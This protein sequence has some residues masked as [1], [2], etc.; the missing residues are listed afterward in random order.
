MQL[1][2]AGYKL[3]SPPK[4]EPEPRNAHLYLYTLYIHT[5]VSTRVRF[6]S[7][8]FLI[9][10]FFRG[11][12]KRIPVQQIEQEGVM[13]GISGKASAL[14]LEGAGEAKSL[15][16]ERALGLGKILQVTMG[17]SPALTWSQLRPRM[18]S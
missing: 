1:T 4:K 16:V 18:D 10:I 7:F 17:R 2:K 5:R 12:L 15:A 9:S 14:R 13:E 6:L 11:V 3:K 8:L